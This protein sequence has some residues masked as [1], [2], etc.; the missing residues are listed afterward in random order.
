[1]NIVRYS[2][3]LLLISAALSTACAQIRFDQMSIPA[4]LSKAKSVGK[5]LFV[6]TYAE[7]CIPCKKMKRVFADRA[8]AQYFNDN[9]V[10]IK[11]DMDTPR[12]K[13]TY[14]DYDVIFLPTMMIFDEDGNL[15]YKTDKLLTSQELLSIGRQAN[16]AGVYLGDNASKIVSSPI[17]KVKPPQKGT[18]KSTE[19]LPKGQIAIELPRTETP[20]APEDDLGNIVYVLGSDLAQAPPE[21]LYQESYFRLQLM[22]GSHEET[23]AAYLSTQTDWSTPENIKF[24]YDFVDRTGTPLFDYMVAHQPLFEK[25]VGREQLKRGLSILVNQRISQGYPRPSLE[26]ALQLYSY[27]NPTNAKRYAYEYYLQTL[28]DGD[29][30]EEYDQIAR[31]YIEQIS[32]EEVKIV[33][34]LTRNY[35]DHLQDQSTP[36]DYLKYQKKIVDMNPDHPQALILL[37]R[38]YIIDGNHKKARQ[39]ALKAQDIIHEDASQLSSQID[40]IL[41]DLDKN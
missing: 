12:G 22:D 4:G 26:E 37:A 6:D 1:M 18:P 28:A 36:K 34:A 29:D 7:W 9:Y 41:D 2:L 23:V 31:E 32:N 5:N 38:L 15:K 17:Q 8:V 10:N 16:V 3:L 39:A 11:I 24:I 14:K 33:N 19:T 30:Y 35:I 20:P 27:V 13:Q 21:I 25:V 40:A